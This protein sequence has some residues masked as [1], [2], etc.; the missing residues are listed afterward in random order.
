MTY[1]RNDSEFQIVILIAYLMIYVLYKYHI[2]VLHMFTQMLTLSCKTNESCHNNLFSM[3][4]N[5]N[6]MF[7]LINFY[8]QTP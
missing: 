5:S 1:M 4:C 6:Y 3:L 2:Q 7:T 8:Q